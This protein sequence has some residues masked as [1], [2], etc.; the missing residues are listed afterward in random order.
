MRKLLLIGIGVGDPNHLT[1]QAIN[2]LQQVDVFFV[3]DKG[4]DK[5]DLVALRTEIFR[6]HRTDGE[7]RTVELRDPERD[8]NPDDY[9]SAVQTWHDQRATVYEQAITNALGGD[10]CGAFLVWGDPAI[11]DSTLRIIE[12]IIATELVALDL[13]VIPGISSI[14]VLAARH[15]IALNRI[16]ESVHITTGR[17]LAAG[18]IPEH[19]D[20]VVMLDGT[21]A[22]T[23]VT[24]PVDIYWG[25]YLGTPHE[26]LIN[27]P[28]HEVSDEIQRTR[29]EARAAHGWIM[30]IYLLRRSPAL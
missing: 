27:G 22:F 19:G 8:R 3:I 10:E 11:Y 13:E 12:Q 7:Y 1:L 28:L 4:P 15:R 5:D 9:R 16:G 14:Q 26:L 2:A 24:E 18:L 17:N 29:A 6:R 23:T 25:A 21:C 20:V 30:D